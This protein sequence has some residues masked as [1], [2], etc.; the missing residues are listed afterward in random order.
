MARYELTELHERIKDCDVFFLDCPGIIPDI[1]KMS[2]QIGKMVGENYLLFGGVPLSASNDVSRLAKT[3]RDKYGVTLV[4]L[5]SHFQY[6]SYPNADMY[7][8]GT[9]REVVDQLIKLRPV[10]TIRLDGN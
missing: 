8:P 10:I 3:V 7:V 6:K 5:T 1:E 9:A 4:V 2:N